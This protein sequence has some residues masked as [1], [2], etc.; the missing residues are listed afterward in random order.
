VRLEAERKGRHVEEDEV[1]DVA[2]QDAR[3]DR[4]ADGDDLVGVDRAVWGLPEDRLDHLLDLR[5]RVWPPTRITVSTCSGERPA[6]SSA[7][8]H[9][10]SVRAMR[11]EASASNVSRVRSLLMCFGPDASEAMNGS[12]TIVSSGGRKLALRLLGR[13]LEA[14]EGEAVLAQVDP[15][16]LQ[17]LREE[18]VHDRAVEVLAA[19]EGVAR[20]REDLEHPVVDPQDRDVERAAAEV[21]DGD[22]LLLAFFS[23]P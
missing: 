12:A 21:V 13:L 5:V 15:A 6:A 20:R 17:E 8:L 18:P 2:A 1:L 14:L 10:P 22:R 16:R 7:F 3:L 23:R 9:G 4:G 19:E 11:S